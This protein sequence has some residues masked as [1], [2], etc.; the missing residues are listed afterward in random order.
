MAVA[1]VLADAEHV[2]SDRLGEPRLLDQQ[3]YGLGV[4]QDAV[5]V[6]GHLAERVQTQL[7]GSSCLLLTR[8]SDR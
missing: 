7:E 4:A 1:V 3:P 8:D 2:E 6:G 5:A